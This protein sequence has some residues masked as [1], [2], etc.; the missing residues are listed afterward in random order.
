[1][2]LFPVIGLIN[3]NISDCAPIRDVIQQWASLKLVRFAD[4]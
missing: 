2:F 3:K 4:L 1:M